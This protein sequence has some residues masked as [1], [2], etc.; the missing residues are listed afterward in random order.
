LP[1]SIEQLAIAARD[2]LGDGSDPSLV[3]SLDPEGSEITARRDKEISEGSEDPI[4]LKPEVRHSHI[5]NQ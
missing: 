3:A 2:T 5:V 4:S 1:T